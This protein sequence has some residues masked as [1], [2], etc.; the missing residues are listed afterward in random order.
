MSYLVTFYD[1]ASQRVRFHGVPIDALQA[2][3][4]A[5]GI[6]L[7]RYPSRPELFETTFLTALSD[8]RRDG[9]TS[10]F[11]GNIHL[12]DVR[13]WYEQ[14]TTQAGLLHY[15][16]LW[17]EEP[18]RLVREGIARGYL[19][20]LTCIEVERA[21]TAWLG[22]RLDEALVEEFEQAG[23]DPCGERGEYH[24]FVHAGPI[25]RRSLSLVLGE[26]REQDGFRQID[27]RLAAT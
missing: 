21:K 9:I 7:L 18:G 11:F 23:I 16:P 15:E 25:F 8:L 2:Q 26:V 6:P 27:L 24:T 1:E 4:D 14:R 5:V 20:T 17:G 10:I 22:A 13:A 19:A 12:E 3:A